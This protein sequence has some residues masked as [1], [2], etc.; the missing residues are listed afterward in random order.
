MASNTASYERLLELLR[1]TP[2]RRL[3]TKEKLVVMSDFHMG[4]GGA[5]D[6]FRHN[7]PLCLHAL[8]EFYF[9]KGYTLLLNGDIE[10][11]L[12]VPR[13]AILKA[14]PG[15]YD[16]F[17]RF[18]AENR[19]IWLLGN[20]EILPS[21]ADEPFY[22]DHFDGESI[23]LETPHGS[24][25][26]FHG[27]QAGVA[28]SG[29]YNGLIGWSL[30]FFANSLGI[31]NRSIAHN[32]AKKFKLEKAIYEF[33]R[34]EEL[35]SIIGHTHRP[36]FESLSKRE[37]LGIR[38]EKLCRD[39]ADATGLQRASIRRTVRDLKTAY[40]DQARHH[41]APVTTVYGEMPVPCMFNAGCAVGK[42]GFTVLEM[43]NGKIGLVA[44]SKSTQ[45]VILRRE[46]LDYVF[47]RIELLGEP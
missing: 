29:R 1:T 32:S 14:W 28:N 44:W 7:G 41:R 5:N 40:L 31:G 36:L 23:L 37:S 16:V 2:R 9:P 17:A 38:I 42:R 43:K 18:R 26:V 47:S 20:H 45:R 34:S 35:I 24:L 27:H 22:R 13:E 6:D 19:L 8:E 30:K 11:L 15:L 10:E 4:D 33:S 39:Y 46:A 21:K 12:R 3:E 25:F